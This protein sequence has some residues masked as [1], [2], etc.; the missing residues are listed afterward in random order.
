MALRSDLAARASAACATTALLGF[1]WAWNYWLS[2]PAALLVAGGS[3]AVALLLAWAS[4]PLVRRI[5]AQ[6]A[7]LGSAAAAFFVFG[8]W[9]AFA[10][11]SGPS[12]D[13]RNLQLA[14]FAGI[15]AGTA[16]VAMAVA[17]FGTF[18]IASA[19]AAAVIVVLWMSPPE[20][21]VLAGPATAAVQPSSPVVTRVAVI[22]ID[23]ADWQVIDPLLAAGA[24]PNLQRVIERGASGV[25]RAVEPTYSPV[26]W[27]SIFTGKTPAKHGITGWY[28][29][30]S[31]N[32]HASR[33]WRLVGGAGWSSVV[34]NVPG[35]WPPKQMSGA[36]VSGFPIPTI[37]RPP[38]MQQ[39][40]VLGRVLAT[41]DRPGSLVPTIVLPVH[42]QSAEGDA[43]IGEAMLPPKTRLHHFGIEVLQRRRLLPPRLHHV[44]VRFDVGTQGKRRIEVAHHAAELATGEW[45]PWFK[46]EVLGQPVRFR[47]R[48]LASGGFY[49]TPFFQDPQQPLYVLASD[50]AIAARAIGDDMYVVE[51]AGW[52]IA[53]DPDLR[54]PLAEQLR[55]LEEQH[56]RVSMALAKEI[57]DWKL[58]V[59]IF[60]L[61]DRTS[62]A[63][64]RFHDAAAYPSIDPAELSENQG[65]LVDAYRYVD[66]RLGEVLAILPEDTTIFLVSDHGSAPSDD[67]I[68]GSHRTDGV[69]IAA[70]PGI[71]P[72]RARLELSALDIT[73]TILAAFGLPEAADMDGLARV[74][75]LDGVLERRQIASYESGNEAA[76]TPKRIDASTENQL[77]S[78]GYVQ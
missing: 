75:I 10:A 33:L 51:G 66:A 56:L 50:P 57:P 58:F 8:V 63:F 31:D 11:L 54:A 2:I 40:Q 70:G 16:I 19:A 38:P 22:G 65:R 48:A 73:P 62:H 74:E 60:T 24:L 9:P 36:L 13:H 61:I 20:P 32:L 43:V 12:A 35:T 49:C 23:S 78:L 34:V 3:V 67:R 77:R 15:G 64:W 7:V 28:D 4:G 41:E 17:R 52:R 44:P 1:A 42:G 53:E 69:W 29:A 21:G 14:L 55:D 25:L 47:L 72:Q 18:D 6:H 76:A 30:R 26:V 68:W 5:C 39:Q 46:H 71:R 27:T 59:H 45:S 37:L